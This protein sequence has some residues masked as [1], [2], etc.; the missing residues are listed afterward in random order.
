MNAF[1]HFEYRQS[2]LLHSF[3]AFLFI[4]L[5]FIYL[6]IY[7]FIHPFTHPFIRLF[8]FIY[9]SIHSVCL[10]TFQ[11]LSSVCGTT[12][13]SRGLISRLLHISIYLPIPKR[14]FCASEINIID[15]FNIKFMHSLYLDPVM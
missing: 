12:C 2:Q 5:F 4:Y 8:I 15:V 11:S 6:F 14:N 13:S 1:F 9:L 3:L 7:L 10:L